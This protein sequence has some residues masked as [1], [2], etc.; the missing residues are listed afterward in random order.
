MALFLACLE[1][2]FIVRPVYWPVFHEVYVMTIML[3]T[4]VKFTTD[5]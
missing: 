3:W 1:S 4:Q 2:K 5:S